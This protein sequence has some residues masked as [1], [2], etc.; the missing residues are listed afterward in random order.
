MERLL[1]HNDKFEVR[2]KHVKF[3]RLKLTENTL[4]TRT[5]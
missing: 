2:V 5:F 4:L 3:V 1:G